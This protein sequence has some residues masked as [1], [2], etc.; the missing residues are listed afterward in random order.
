M[1]VFVSYKREAF[2]AEFVARFESALSDIA[3]FWRDIYRIEPGQDWASEIDRAINE[4]QALVLV[5]SKAGAA[6]PYV[7]YEWAYALG[8]GLQ[9]VPLLA[10][11]GT[12]IH[13]R[14]AKLH[15]VDCTQ[16]ERE[17]FALV[18]QHLLLLSDPSI[19]QIELLS[20]KIGAALPRDRLSLTR[21]LL[22]IPGKRAKEEAAKLIEPTVN[23]IE[24]SSLIEHAEAEL[25]VLMELHHSGAAGVLSRLAELNYRL[26][27]K[28]IARAPVASALAE[29][30]LS[31]RVRR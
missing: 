14:L 27:E 31:Q 23:R 28:S 25:K 3:V 12:P 8:A 7:S 18:R 24:A 30:A 6:S 16:D 1:N 2:E 11:V 21:Q 13:S 17:A 26:S 19:R 4:S 10:E 9:V 29:L 20:R 5:M 22:A 15:Q